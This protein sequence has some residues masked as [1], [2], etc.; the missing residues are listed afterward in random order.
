MDGNVCV[1]PLADAKPARTGWEPATVAIA[2]LVVPKSRPS[3][4]DF[5]NSSGCIRYGNYFTVMRRSSLGST[6]TSM[7]LYSTIEA[8]EWI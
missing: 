7:S 6:S 1:I 2:L 4:P 5:E 3:D 8:P